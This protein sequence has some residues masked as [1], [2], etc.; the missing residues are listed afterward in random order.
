MVVWK[1]HSVTNI[2]KDMFDEE[3]E[4]EEEEGVDKGGE[5]EERR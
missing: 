1:G 3:V 4:E 5:K 2:G